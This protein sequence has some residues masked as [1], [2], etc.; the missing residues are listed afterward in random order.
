MERKVPRFGVLTNSLFDTLDEIREIGEMGFDFVEIGFEPPFGLPEILLKKKRDILD[1]LRKYDMSAIA[2][3][4]WWYDLG[5]LHEKVRKAWVEEGKVAIDAARQLG[6]RTVNFHSGSF[7]MSMQVEKAKKMV[8]DN[9]VRSL[10]E[11][12]SYGKKRGIAVMLENM[13]EKG[14]VRLDD[15]RYIADR[16]SSLW[17][18]LDVGHAFIAGGNDEVAKY[19]RVFRDR[20][21]HIHLHDNHGV[22]DEHLP[23]GVASLDYRRLASELKKIG[24]GNTI[25]FEVFTPDR[26]Y[27]R[28]SME[29]MKSL[30]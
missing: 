9:M 11:L 15:F 2:H 6:I 20:I 25:T 7:G 27:C 21:L 14:V 22:H 1:A 30:W 26:D 13:P 8:F 17:V 4:S 10:R 23:I 5:S 12:T 16:V 28:I 18:H 19:I 29:K 24:Y 3:T